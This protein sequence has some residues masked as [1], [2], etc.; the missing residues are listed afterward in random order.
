M[1]F[2]RSFFMIGVNLLFR[3]AFVIA[4]F[5]VKTQHANND[6]KHVKHFGGKPAPGLIDEIVNKPQG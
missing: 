3:Y 2:R 4:F 6:G 5:A 1:H